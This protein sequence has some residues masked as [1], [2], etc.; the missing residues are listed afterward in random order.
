MDGPEILQLTND[1][2]SHSL[3]LGDGFG[4]RGLTL[5]SL[6]SSLTFL[7]NLI[8]KFGFLCVLC[9]FSVSLIYF[10]LSLNTGTLAGDLF[11]NTLLFALVDIPATLISFYVLQWGIIGEI[12]VI[13]KSFQAEREI[14]KLLS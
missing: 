2:D 8:L 6:F 5:V 3:F 11:L 9:R 12:K 13:F 7:P 4:A 1:H 14:K 10:A